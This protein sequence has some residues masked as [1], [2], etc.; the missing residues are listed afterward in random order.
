M[1]GSGIAAVFLANRTLVR[2]LLLAR[3]RDEAETEDVLQEMWLRLETARV[4]PVGDPLAYLMRMAQ[5]L[6]SDRQI[7]AQRR[8]A[9][10]GSWVAVQPGSAELPD[11]ERQLVSAEELA[12][13]QSLIGSMPERMHRALVLFRLEGRS[14]RAIAEELGMSVSGVGKLL[15][16]AYRQLIDFRSNTLAAAGEPGSPARGDRSKAND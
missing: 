7:A 1:A 8:A 6:A 2:R 11:A 4:G 16:R 3:T 10:E 13:L 9:R 15:V 14:H 5:N 12:R